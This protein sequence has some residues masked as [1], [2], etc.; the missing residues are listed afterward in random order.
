MKV[1]EKLDGVGAGQRC[2]GR[3]IK[4]IASW[5]LTFLST[6]VTAAERESA[7]NREKKHKFYY[8]TP[9]SWMKTG[10]V[11]WQLRVQADGLLTQIPSL[12]F[13][14]LSHN[15][16]LSSCDR[17][18]H[19]PLPSSVLCYFDSPVFPCVLC[20]LLLFLFSR[21]FSPINFYLCL[22]V[23]RAH[24]C[25]HLCFSVWI[26]AVGLNKIQRRCHPCSDN[27]FPN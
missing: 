20:N 17:I 16:T 23:S 25:A 18:C 10:H 9:I 3:L 26:V 8:R 7:Q 19:D 5:L 15:A 4:K 1:E 14:L 27:S 6:G 12:A 11:W 13:V 22:V 24:D 2:S 21:L